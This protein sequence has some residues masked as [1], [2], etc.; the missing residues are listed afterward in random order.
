MEM[1]KLVSRFNKLCSRLTVRFKLYM[2][3]YDD[4]L[5]VTDPLIQFVHIKAEHV[6]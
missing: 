2:S 3:F 5:A 6:G 1:D 4:A